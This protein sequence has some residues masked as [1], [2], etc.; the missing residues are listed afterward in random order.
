MVFSLGKIK[1]PG[2]DSC[3]FSLLNHGTKQTENRAII[4]YNNKN[5]MAVLS[6]RYA[7]CGSRGWLIFVNFFFFLS[8][9]SNSKLKIL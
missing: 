2:A 4:K 8:R 3:E 1:P 6:R 9:N 7:I 5:R